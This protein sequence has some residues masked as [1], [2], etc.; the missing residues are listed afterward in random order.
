M[1]DAQGHE[2]MIMSFYVQGKPA[3]Y[4]PPADSSFDSAGNWLHD[5]LT[6]ITDVTLDGAVTWSRE[7]ASDVWLQGKRVFKY[8]SG[9]PLPT[10]SL[11]EL[12]FP[13]EKESRPKDNRG[14]WSFAGMFSSIRGAKGGPVEPAPKPDGRTYT[15]GEVHAD[16]IK[17]FRLSRCFYFFFEKR[18]CSE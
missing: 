5:K 10:K 12:P 9:S 16:L 11:P 6:G 4:Q 15:D 18:I 3:G 8:L 13:E 1:V 14:A 17:V 2:H 7:C